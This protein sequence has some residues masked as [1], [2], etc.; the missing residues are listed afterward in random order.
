MTSN[1]KTRWRVGIRSDEKPIVY[2]DVVDYEDEAEVE[3]AFLALCTERTDEGALARYI[4]G[5]N[6]TIDEVEEMK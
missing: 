1:D 2:V 4:Y 6:N 5:S 3:A